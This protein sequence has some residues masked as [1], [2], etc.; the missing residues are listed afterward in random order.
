MSLIMQCP[1]HPWVIPATCLSQEGLHPILIARGYWYCTDSTP[2]RLVK[3][4][5]LSPEQYAEFQQ[6]QAEQLQQT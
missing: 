6:A 2:W 5:V 3:P 4:V 1:L